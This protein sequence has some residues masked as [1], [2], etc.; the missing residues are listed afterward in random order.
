MPHAALQVSQDEEGAVVL[1][2]PHVEPGCL[3][4]EEVSAC[5]LSLL[6]QDAEQHTGGKI[7]KAVISV[8]AYFDDNQREAT[9]LAGK[10]GPTTARADS[11]D[12]NSTMVYS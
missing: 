12:A 11:Y 8:P 1:D 5:V 2:C 4:P 3:Y 6:L 10:Q 7:T 9:I